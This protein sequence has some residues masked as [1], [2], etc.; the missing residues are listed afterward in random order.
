MTAFL[1]LSFVPS[2]GSGGY[3]GISNAGDI[4]LI[5]SIDGDNTTDT[6]NGLLIA[7]HTQTSGGLKILENGNV[8]IGV[9][10]PGARLQVNGSTSDTSANAFIARNSSGTSLFSVR[11]DGR[12]DVPNGAIVHAGGGYANTSTND[13]YFTGDLGIGTTAPA[14]KLDISSTGTAMARIISSDGGTARFDLHS[15]GNS[16]Y[17]LSA[18]ASN[19]FLLFDEVESDTAVRYFGGSSGKWIFRTNNLE[20]FNI[21]SDGQIKLNTYGTATHTG[22]ATKTLQVDSSGNI[23]EGSIVNFA[24]KVEYQTVAA[25]IAANT[26]ITL[27]NSLT[28]TISSGGYEYLEVFIDGIRLMRDIDFEEISTSSIKLLMAVPAS[29]VFTFKSIT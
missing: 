9:A 12:V 21:E 29:S 25:N 20:R 1:F 16:R 13:S 23:I 10:T 28:Y 15:S 24:P 11:N 8:G 22:T 3:T 6:T 5:F 4:G 26:T 27:P 19:G 14:H 18:L 17:S 2:L 7:P